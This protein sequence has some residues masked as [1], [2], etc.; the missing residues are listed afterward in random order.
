MLKAGTASFGAVLTWEL[1]VLAILKGDA[2]RAEM[3]FKSDEKSGRYEGH[4]R[5]LTFEGIRMKILT[6]KGYFCI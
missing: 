4:F 1:E 5:I 2:Y 3:L 6:K